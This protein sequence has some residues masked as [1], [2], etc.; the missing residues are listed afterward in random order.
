MPGLVTDAID[1]P[2]PRTT[3]MTARPPLV[4]LHGVTNSARIWDDVVPLLSDD[5]EVIAP[6]AAGHRGGPSAPA[7]LTIARLVDDVEGLLDARGLPQAHL[8]GNSMGGWMALE[9]ARRGRALSVCALSP[10]GCWT[11]GGRDETHA[12]STIRTGR[13]LA[14]VAGPLVPLALRSQRLRRTVLRDAAEHAD[15][16]TPSQ[17]VEMVRDLAACTAAPDLLG[18]TEYVQPLTAPCPITLAWSLRDRIFPPE[19]NGTNARRLIPDATYLELADVG[20]IP[21]IDDPALCASVIR[22]ACRS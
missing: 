15:R 5:F 2:D 9:L 1:A 3:A 18:T 6:T 4:L 8:A 14:R 19:I 16:L 7:G 20:H 22:Q 17:A 10:A 21:M 13:R 12:T 11:P